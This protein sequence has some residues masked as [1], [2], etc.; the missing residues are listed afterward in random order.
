MRLQY[1]WKGMI[2]LECVLLILGKCVPDTGM[3]I[4]PETIGKGIGLEREALFP[5]SFPTV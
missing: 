3:L 1:Y 5:L 2:F 4:G